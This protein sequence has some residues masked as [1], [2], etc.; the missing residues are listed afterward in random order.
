M[1]RVDQKG[2][3]PLA[4]EAPIRDALEKLAALGSTHGIEDPVIQAG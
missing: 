4:A 1:P 3:Q 2:H